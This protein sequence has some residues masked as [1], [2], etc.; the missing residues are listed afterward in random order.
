MIIQ[1]GWAR[2][3]LMELLA[4]DFFYMIKAFSSY[5]NIRYIHLLIGILD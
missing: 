1:I 4:N 5:E 2:K 3:T